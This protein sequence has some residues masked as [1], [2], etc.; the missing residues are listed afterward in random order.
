MKAVLVKKPGLVAFLKSED[1]D[2][3]E[4]VIHNTKH[5]VIEYDSTQDLFYL[6]YEYCKFLEANKLANR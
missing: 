2:F 3:E 5:L 4:T 6:G 1:I